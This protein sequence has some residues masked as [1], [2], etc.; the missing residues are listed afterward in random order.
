MRALNLVRHQVANYY[1]SQVPALPGRLVASYSG[2]PTTA[3]IGSAATVDNGLGYVR[4][5]AVGQELSIMADL[6]VEPRHV[7]REGIF[8]VLIGGGN[9][10]FIAYTNRGLAETLWD[11]SEGSLLPFLQTPA[12]L[13]SVEYLQL[14][15]RLRVDAALAGRRL[16]IFVA[17]RVMDSQELIFTLEPLLLDIVE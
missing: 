7:G 13:R 6:H 5:V 11:G 9:D 2:Q 14:L 17:Y 12:P 4:S 8:H 3:R 10:E 1:A 16:E 15:S